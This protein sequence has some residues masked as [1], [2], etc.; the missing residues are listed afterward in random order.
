M[1]TFNHNFETLFNIEKTMAKVKNVAIDAIVATAAFSDAEAFKSYALQYTSSRTF[2]T[3]KPERIKRIEDKHK[4]A[5]IA[6]MLK[7]DL[8]ELGN[9]IIDSKEKASYLIKYL[10]FKI[11][12][13]GETSDVLEASTISPLNI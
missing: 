1:Y 12:K 11:F 7:I 4:R 8:D 5:D 9:F 13:D 10:C 2:I 6:N 3:L